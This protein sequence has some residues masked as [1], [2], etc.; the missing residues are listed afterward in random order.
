ME[1][2]VGEKILKGKMSG[3]GQEE[4]PPE[5]T[6]TKTNKKESTDRHRTGR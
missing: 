2:Y 4:R 6:E 5:D 1:A 3:G